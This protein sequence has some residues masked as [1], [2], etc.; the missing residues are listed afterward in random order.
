[1]N[2]FVYFIFYLT[3]CAFLTYCTRESAINAQNALHE[4]RTLPGVSLNCFYCLVVVLLSI[5]CLLSCLLVSRV[6]CP[7]CRL[8][9]WAY[10]SWMISSGTALFLSDNNKLLYAPPPPPL[11]FNST[12]PNVLFFLF[13]SLAVSDR[14]REA[15]RKR[16]VLVHT[17][18]NCHLLTGKCQPSLCHS[19]P[20]QFSLCQAP[21]PPPPLLSTL[22]N[23]RDGVSLQRLEHSI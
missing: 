17:Y 6:S 18:Y 12:L 23:Q 15:R 9:V 8:R 1:M 19:R 7:T 5:T 20:M 13:F 14:K 2:E 21:P 22:R 10:K 16:M 4:K 11:D 3:G